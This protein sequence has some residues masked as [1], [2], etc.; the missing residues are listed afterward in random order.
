MDT[1]TKLTL[2]GFSKTRSLPM[3]SVLVTC[4][5]STIGKMG[6]AGRELSTNQQINSVVVNEG[7]DNQFVY[8]NI[9]S[10]FPRYLKEV[11]V[12]A[13][14]ILSKSSFE[15]LPT[16]KTSLA[17]QKRIGKLLSLIDDRIDT[18]SKVIEDLKRLKS[19]ITDLVF[20]LPDEPT[21]SKRLGGFSN[22]WKV[23]RLSDICKRIR[24]KN[25]GERCQLVLTIAAQHG[26]VGQ[27]DFFNKSVASDNLE[28]YYLLQRGDFAYN[29]SYSGDYT[30]GAV[31]RLERYEQGVL[32]PLYICF[33]PDLSTVNAEYLSHY[34]ESKKWHKGVADI[35]GEGARN[36]G[37]LNISVVDYFNTL[38]RLPSLEEQ[39]EIAKC[40]NFMQE[41]LKLEQNILNQF[42][43]QHHYLLRQMFI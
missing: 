3:G 17:E 24:T 42:L 33:R 22:E 38:H 37:L 27:E 31:K 7:F 1:A 12:Q 39:R 2:L 15:K 5:G 21:P 8:Y 14:P 20:C 29:K 26:L 36:H 30:W 41:K 25:T 23:V 10:A 19:A 43:I 11:A 6:M 35:A 4:I 28:G 16:W 34:F 13:V 32:S 18:Q 40:L 9:M